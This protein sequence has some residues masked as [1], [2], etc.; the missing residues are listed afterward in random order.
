[1]FLAP[2]HNNQRQHSICNCMKIV[3]YY[4]AQPP[5]NKL[6]TTTTKPSVSSFPHD[7]DDD[8]YFIKRY[9]DSKNLNVSNM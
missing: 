2:C 9:T 5:L 6:T 1:M 3:N 8:N 4:V 7:Y